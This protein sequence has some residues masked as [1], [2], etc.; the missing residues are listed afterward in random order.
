[1]EMNIL[2]IEMES[3]SFFLRYARYR[4]IAYRIILRLKMGKMKRDNFLR[5]SGLSEI[6]FLPERV[7]P[8]RGIRA[9]PRKG[10]DDFYM[11][12][13]PR[14][15]GLL[16]HLLMH[17]DETFVDVGANVGY[18]TLKIAKEYSREGVN[19]IAIEAHPGNYKAL[20]KNIVLNNFK[21]ITTINKAVSD[22]KGIVT[23][24]ERVDTAN[25][26]R[27]EFFSLSNGFIHELN[28]VRPGEHSLQ[29]ECDTLDNIL[30]GQSVDVMKI[31]IEGAEVSA[32][33]GAT[34]ILKKLRKIIVEV[35][36]TNYNKV[37]QILDDTR[38]FRCET[39]QGDMM[40]FI[41]G[42]RL[43]D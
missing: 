24:Y 8:I 18:Y 36:G 31:D 33:E 32:L 21:C 41:I 29:I 5:K 30:G 34:R 4:Y 39:I 38:H 26:I 6:D 13:I 42:T 17:P 40:N 20:C 3:L 10:S 37:M 15:K 11:F 23:M 9:I 28:I 22:Q 27:S 12:Y 2:N 16:S 43:S 19:I 25:R 14:E 7:Y 1:M 35:H